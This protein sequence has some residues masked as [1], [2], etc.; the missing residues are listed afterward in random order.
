MVQSHP[1]AQGGNMRAF[2]MAALVFLL[3]ILGASCTQSEGN[4]WYPP[5]SAADTALA[6]MGGPCPPDMILVTPPDEGGVLGEADPEKLVDAHGGAYQ[7]SIRRAPLVP[8]APYCIAA[9]PFPGED[10]QWAAE[11]AYFELMPELE[12]RLAEGGRRLCSVSELLLAAAGPK[13]WR[14]ATHPEGRQE[15]LC[16]SNDHTPSR[17]IGGY[18]RCASPLGA[19][20][21][22]IRS[23]WAR[24]EGWERE[25]LVEGGVPSGEILPYGVYGGTAREDTF[26]PPTNFSLHFHSAGLMEAGGYRDDDLRVCADPGAVTPGEEAEWGE[27]QGL[28]VERGSTYR[29]WLK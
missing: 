27:S 4:N 26:Y 3:G 21:F 15:G 16:E 28:F 5:A 19:R 25:L 2:A 8:R 23:S 17:P 10:E 18:E 24:V 12:V 13:N 1:T 6:E 7:Y 11:A 20:D 22:N 29:D 9:F 14:Y